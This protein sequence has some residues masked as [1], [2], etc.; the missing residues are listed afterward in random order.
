VVCRNNSIF[1]CT[2]GIVSA[3]GY[4]RL[5]SRGNETLGATPFAKSGSNTWANRFAYY[6]PVNTG[7]VY[8]DAV[9]NVFRGAVQPPAGGG[10]Y[11]YGDND[12]DYVL[13]TAEGAGHYVPIADSDT[14]DGGILYGAGEEGSG[15]TSEGV[16]AAIAAALATGVNLVQVEGTDASDAIKAAAAAA[17]TDTLEVARL[18]ACATH[19]G[20]NALLAAALD[21]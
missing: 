9:G 13:T 6:A 16:E 19:Q 1:N 10:G 15:M 5:F 11:T 18:N 12:P 7:L 2:A 8:G 14:V 20:V 3:A 4:D 21:G 17:L